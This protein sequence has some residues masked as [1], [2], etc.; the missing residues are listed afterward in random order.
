M[1]RPPRE[2]FPWLGRECK[3]AH[4]VKITEE[5]QTNKDDTQRGTKNKDDSQRGTNN[6][7]N[8]RSVHLNK[9]IQTSKGDN[10]RKCKCSK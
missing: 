6:K 2:T 7:D 10:K 5:I 9:E 3:T 4:F 8:Y 1:E